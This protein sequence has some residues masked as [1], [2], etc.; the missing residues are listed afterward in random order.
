VVLLSPIPHRDAWQDRRDFENFAQWGR[1]VAQ[2]HG[3]LFADLTIVITEGYRR[4]GANVVDTYFSDART[5]TNEA[6]AAFNA[7]RVVAAVKGLP[8]GVVDKWLS[9]QGQ[10]VEA[11]SDKKTGDRLQLN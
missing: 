8:G 2:R 11:V 10:Q 6:G 5:H 3:A 9:A 7:Q 1:E 4:A